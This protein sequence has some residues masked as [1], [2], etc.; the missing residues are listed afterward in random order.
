MIAHLTIEP[1]TPLVT[2]TL[3]QFSRVAEENEWNYEALCQNP[4]D[5]CQLLRGLRALTPPSGLT[6]ECAAE[7]SHWRNS[8]LDPR[9]CASIHVWHGAL[10]E[11]GEVL[12]RLEMPAGVAVGGPE[13]DGASGKVRAVRKPKP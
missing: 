1:K 6:L 9:L 5:A 12:E 13:A 11:T 7:C 4:P 8:P 10:A 3:M 2:R